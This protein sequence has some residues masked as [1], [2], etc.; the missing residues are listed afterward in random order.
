[1]IELVQPA[2]SDLLAGAGVP[3]LCGGSSIG[4]AEFATG[5]RI[6]AAVDPIGAAGVAK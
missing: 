4:A 6:S 2:N 5:A 1:M 3:R